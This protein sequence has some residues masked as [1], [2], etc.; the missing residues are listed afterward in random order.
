M[1]E[2]TPKISV[3]VPV[4]KAENYL[5]RCVDSLLAQTF[6]DF[7]ILLIDDGSP[8]RSGEICDEYARKDK[9]VRVF[10]KENGGVSSARN[11]GLDNAV[12]AY[13]CFVDS[14]DWVEEN[15]LETLNFSTQ[16]RKEL[17]I[18]FFGFQYEFTCEDSQ[19][20]TYAECKL[21]NV[22]A[23]TYERILSACLVLEKNKMFGWTCNKLFRR[24]LI[25][26]EKLYFDETVFLQEDHLF[27]LNYIQYVRNL[28]VLSYNPYHYRISSGSLTQMPHD[29]SERKRVAKLLLQARL[30]VTTKN[31]SEISSIYKN[32][33][34]KSFISDS[35][36][37]A[38]LLYR[39][40]IDYKKRKQEIFFLKQN[41][42]T[43]FCGHDMK[44]WCLRI[45]AMLPLRLFDI[46]C[47]IW[48]EMRN[49][50]RY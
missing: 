44:F 1:N 17:D 4:Y 24:C 15:M 14:D 37:N 49:R 11:V 29:Y 9:R 22:Y 45:L 31:N 8:D 13:I 10:H 7:E 12:G 16:F 27:T 42:L 21:E 39:M 34:Y 25:E 38:S 5:H 46:F 48:V 6:Q 33:A 26:K 3:I 19:M 18:L 32:F 40:G 41:I 28:Q 35:L 23:D 30:T 20:R 47:C 36:Y 2:T 43:Y 50:G